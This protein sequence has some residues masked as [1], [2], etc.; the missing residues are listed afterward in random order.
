VTAK[1]TPRAGA[2]KKA[3]PQGKGSVVSKRTPATRKKV[4]S[5]RAVG[6]RRQAK[7][8]SR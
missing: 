1:S 7:R 4:A 5:T 3:T 6:A 2:K 8:D